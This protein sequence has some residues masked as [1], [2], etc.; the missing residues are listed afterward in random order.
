MSNRD[1][2]YSFDVEVEKKYYHEC[3]SNKF[4]FFY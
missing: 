4:C 1:R 3:L 2:D